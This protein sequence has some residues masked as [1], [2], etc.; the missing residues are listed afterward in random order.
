MP[1]IRLK[2]TP[3][4]GACVILST[5][6]SHYVARVL[7]LRVGDTIAAFDGAGH[8]W[9]LRLTRVSGNQVQAEIIASQLADTTALAPVILGQALPKSAKMDLIVEKCSELGLT[10]LVPLYTERTVVRETPGRLPARF[11]RWQR[12]AEAA[13][14]QCGRH[15]LLDVQGPQSL[16]DFCRHY[17]PVTAKILCWE[18]EGHGGV[19]QLLE[20]LRDAGSYAVLIG[21]EGGWSSAEVDLARTHGFVPVSLGPR[22]LRT[23]TAAIAITSLIRYIRG[24]LETHGERG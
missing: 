10:T 4:N 23:E 19:R 20:S 8:E 22:I 18:G 16:A 3:Q 7:R 2:S 21:P 12:I 24:D 11:A 9:R 14:K 13:A 17:H 15:T 5:A 6:Q 1:R